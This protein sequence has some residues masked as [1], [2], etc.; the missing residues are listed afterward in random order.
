MQPTPPPPGTDL[1]EVVFSGSLDSLKGATARPVSTEPGYE[2]Q[3]FYTPDGTRL[4]FTANRDGKQTDIY[5]VDRKSRQVQQLTKT[6]ESEYS[7]ALTPDGK[8]ISVIRVEADSTQRLWRFDVRGVDPQVVLTQIRPVGYHAWIDQDQLALFVLGKPSTLQHA[9]V[10]TG[11]AVVVA[12]S[13]GRALHRIPGTNRV[14]FVHTENPK[15]VWVK[16][17]DP[18]SGE[19][20]PLVRV[21]DG[22]GERD[23]AWTPDGTLLMTAGTRIFA[24]QRGQKEWREVLDVAGQKLGHVTRMAVAPDGRAL[25]LVI[26]ESR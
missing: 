26:N 20:T 11:K 4:L 3:P 19:I 25:A 13:I 15:D 5:A 18:A 6:T 23:V 12:Q 2:N 16:E 17:F 7:P 8:G 10:S 14:S 22:S 24:W 9:R 1:Y 21:V